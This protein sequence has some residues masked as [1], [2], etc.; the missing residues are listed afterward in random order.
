M[1]ELST[2][3]LTLY[4]NPAGTTFGISGLEQLS[5]IREITIVDNSGKRIQALDLSATSWDVSAL[6]TGMYYVKIAHGNG[7]ETIRLLKK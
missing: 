4:P 6:Q 2:A 5:G 7:V 3:S 1:E